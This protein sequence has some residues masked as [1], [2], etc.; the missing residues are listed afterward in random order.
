MSNQKSVLCPKSQTNIPLDSI[1]PELT[2]IDL[3][4]FQVKF[5]DLEITE[6]IAEGGFGAVFKGKLNGSLVAIKQL[7]ED[8]HEDTAVCPHPHLAF[9]L[10][11]P[12]QAAYREFWREVFMSSILVHKCIVSLKAFTMSPCCM[13]M[14]FMPN[15]NLYSYLHSRTDITWQSKLRMAINIADAMAFLHGQNPKVSI[16]FLM[17]KSESR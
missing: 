5:S 8:A 15:G 1:V 2:M 10:L 9:F 6:K 16:Q 14:E 11:T 4:K 12:T 3:A 17:I 7:I 13:V